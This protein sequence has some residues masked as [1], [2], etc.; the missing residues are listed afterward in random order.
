M[1]IKG[2]NMNQRVMRL[3]HK[4]PVV[5]RCKLCRSQCEDTPCIGT[6]LDIKRLIDNG[7]ADRLLI[8]YNASAMLV[9]Q[10]DHPVKM[11]ATDFRNGKCPFFTADRLCELHDLGLKPLEGRL[12][13]HSTTIGNFRP[14]RS[15]AVNI[16]K[17]WESPDN[18]ELVKELFSH[19]ENV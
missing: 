14:H 17:E 12:S 19:Y 1:N 4:K 18:A 16:L 9:G 2:E 13:H 5:C 8:T 7:Y 3:S 11:I 6:P 15:I 10:L